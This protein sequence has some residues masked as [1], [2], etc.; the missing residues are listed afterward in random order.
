[1]LFLSATL[2]MK[3]KYDKLAFCYAS[4]HGGHRYYEFGLY[5]VHTSICYANFAY[6]IYFKG[7]KGFFCNVKVCQMVLSLFF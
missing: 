2:K 1:M 6:M 5:Y 4:A 3:K 7:V